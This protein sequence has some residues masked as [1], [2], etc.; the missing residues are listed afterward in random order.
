MRYLR[1]WPVCAT[2][3]A[4]AVFPLT[5]CSFGQGRVSEPYHTSIDKAPAT[6]EVHNAVGEIEIDAWDKPSVEIDAEKRGMS[7]D[8]VHRITV[9]VDQRGPTLVVTSHFPSGVSNCRVDYTIHAPATA[10]LD[11][12]QSVGAIESKDFAANVL[13]TTKT[14]A[15]ATTMATLGGAQNVKIS[16]SV[17]AIALE[18]PATS[19]ASFSASTS[20][21]AIKADFPLN[22]QRNMLGST[23]SGSIGKGD[24]HIDLSISTGA[25]AVRRE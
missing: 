19:S 15:I 9:S 13:E 1:V 20:I 2:L 17:G 3:A 4:L 8:D 22:V 11:L 21:G 10:N 25:I 12:E 16:V 5:G 24:A 6:V 18:I 23:A 14:G 7:L